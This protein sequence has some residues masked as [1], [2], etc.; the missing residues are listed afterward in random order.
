MLESDPFAMTAAA[1]QI[2]QQALQLPREEQKEIARILLADDSLAEEEYL[3][4]EDLAKV[5][6][7]RRRVHSGEEKLIDGEVWQAS[8][9]K[10]IEEL[11]AES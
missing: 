1:N 2:V 6:E 11:R 4:P 10:R 3:S 5:E 7:I 8:W 9:R